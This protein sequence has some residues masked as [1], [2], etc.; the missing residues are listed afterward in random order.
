MGEVKMTFKSQMHC[1]LFW[2]FFISVGQIQVYTS[3]QEIN[4]T[5]NER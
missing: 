2:I 3:E 4:Q 5:E 1:P